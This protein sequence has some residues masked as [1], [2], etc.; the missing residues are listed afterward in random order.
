M[1]CLEN[2]TETYHLYAGRFVNSTTKE[3]SLV[4]LSVNWDD[5]NNA[6]VA[7]DLVTNGFANAETDK[8]TTTDL[9]TGETNDHYAVPQT[10][11]DIAPHGHVAKKIKCLP[12]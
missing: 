8:C 6:T 11:A 7:L 4:A 5:V 12:F 2:S 3:G 1:G 10:F 9:W